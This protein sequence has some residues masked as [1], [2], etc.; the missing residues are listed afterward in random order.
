MRPTCFQHERRNLWQ[1]SIFGGPADTDADLASYTV[2]PIDHQSEFVRTLIQLNEWLGSTGHPVAG[3]VARTAKGHPAAIA[4]FGRPGLTI[5]D[6]HTVVL[7]RGVCEPWAPPHCASWFIPKA[8]KLAARDHGWTTFIAYADP[9][10][11]EAGTIYQACNWMYVGNGREN[12]RPRDYFHHIPS[13]KTISE[14]AFRA[15]G[16]TIAD[17]D[18]LV[19]ERLKKSAKHKY[20]W[21]E[22]PPLQKKKLRRQFT[23]LPYPKRTE[24][25][26]KETKVETVPPPPAAAE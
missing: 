4:L 23:P 14:K 8:V 1:D 24:V 12:G 21:I 26:V 25:A 10:A 11:G 9:D 13:D 7:E 5:S 2:G 6:P 3:Y 22:A 16:L 20:V 15:R 17:V 19:W 18:G